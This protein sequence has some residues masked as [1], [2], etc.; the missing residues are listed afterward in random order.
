MKKI[1]EMGQL[2][3]WTI[4]WSETETSKQC[5]AEVCMVDKD[6]NDY[7]V[8]ATYGQDR[9]PFDS[10]TIGETVQIEIGEVRLG[11]VLLPSGLF[12][13]PT[14]TKS[15]NLTKA[16]KKGDEVRFHKD[17]I[18]C[19][20]IVDEVLVSEVDGWFRKITYSDVYRY[21]KQPYL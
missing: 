17:G 2:I 15:I 1:A 20:L 10:A 7:C 5:V 21:T 11:G 9:I 3:E 8:C 6:E 19:G 16:L 12:V 4:D 14:E 13:S 18:F